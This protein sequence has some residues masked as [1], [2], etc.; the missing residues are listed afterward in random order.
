MNLRIDHVA[1]VPDAVEG[2]RDL[3]A[4][5][6]EVDLGGDLENVEEEVHSVGQAGLADDGHVEAHAVE[7]TVQEV[8]NVVQ[9]VVGADLGL[10]TDALGHGDVLL[11]LLVHV[12]HADSIL[13]GE[14]PG[15]V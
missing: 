15:Q 9:V 4:L 7:N 10:G 12:R 11:S 8:L 13:Q 6:G 1:G 2:G 3:G 14:H 5:P